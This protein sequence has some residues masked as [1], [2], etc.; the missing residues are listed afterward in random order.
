MGGEA[1]EVEVSTEVV[2]ATEVLVSTEVLGVD[3][4]AVLQERAKIYDFVG[5]D[6]GVYP[7][8]MY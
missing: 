2:V 4:L 7:I 1:T 6:K 3:Q 8:A 5:T